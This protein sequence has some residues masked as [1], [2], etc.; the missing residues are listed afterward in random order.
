MEMM[1]NARN[2]PLLRSGGVWVASQPPVETSGYNYHAPTEQVGTAGTDRAE[3]PDQSHKSHE[4]RSGQE[5]LK[6]A[7]VE[8]VSGEQDGP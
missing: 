6:K 5:T 1:V 3:Y 4:S 8:D 7:M 2:M